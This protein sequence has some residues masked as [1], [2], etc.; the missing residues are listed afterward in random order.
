MPPE[1]AR[2]LGLPGRSARAPP[3]RATNSPA[4]S[5]AWGLS[6]GPNTPA[7]VADNGTGLSTLYSGATAS[8]KGATTL[9]LVVK[10]PQGAPTGT[11]FNG[12][13]GFRID[14]GASPFLFS[15]EAGVISGWNPAFGTAARA[16]SSAMGAIYKGLAIATSP[17]GPRLYATDFHGNPVNV[18]DDVDPVP[19]EV[20][21]V[22]ARGVP[23]RGDREPL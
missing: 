9:P 11:V 22:Q 18:W 16:A 4:T 5:D 12:G 19:V 3:D 10:I 2:V 1:G 20:G 6:F 14:G 7:W 23:D 8:G 13:D 15:S 21:C 17:D